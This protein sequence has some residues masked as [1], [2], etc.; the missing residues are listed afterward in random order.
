MNFLTTQPMSRGDSLKE[1][2]EQAAVA[3][4]AY[5]TDIKS[6]SIDKVVEIQVQGEDMLSLLYQFLDEVLF[7]FNAE[8]NLICKKVE[9]VEFDQ[10]E[11][12]IKAR[13]CG[14]VFDLDKHP[15]GTEIKAITYS[16]MQIHDKEVY[17]IIDI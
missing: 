12:T 3:M 1:A 13:C 14:E 7:L 9:I 6:V 5:M 2:F 8:P 17:V 4:S 15:Q 11:F 16:N 10:E